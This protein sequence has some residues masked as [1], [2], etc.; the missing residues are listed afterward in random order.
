MKLALGPLLY[1]WPRRQVLEFYREIAHSPVDIVYLGETVCSRRHE[2]RLPD[3]LELAG[4]LAAAGKEAVLSTQALIESESDLK[5]VRKI[6]ANGRFLVEANDMGA[7]RLLEH[8]G[9]FVAGPSLNVYNP[10]TLAFLAGLGAHRWVAPV[11]LPHDALTELQQ[12]RPEAVET[13]VLVYGRLPLAHSARCFT[14]RRYNLQKD[15]CAFRCIEH[16]DGLA[17]ATREGRP[18]LILNGLQTQ[19]AAVLNL[20][21]E[22]PAMAAAGIDVVRLSPQSAHAADVIALFREALGHPEGTATERLDALAPGAL[23]NGYWH[24]A[25][26]ME[27]RTA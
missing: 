19:S 12:R 4:M 21:A 20:V 9:P 16:A 15:D 23:C 5:T 25:P 14:A 22:L 10:Q 8:R 1:Y 13:E 7:V 3:W 18:F 6:A 11:E 17:L 27:R 26:G 24:G 2:L